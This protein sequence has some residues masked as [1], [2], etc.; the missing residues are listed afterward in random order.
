[1]SSPLLIS[2]ISSYSLGPLETT[3]IHWD[4]LRHNDHLLAIG[5]RYYM[6]ELGIFSISEQNKQVRYKA[7][8]PAGSL[9]L[10]KEM[11]LHS[12]S[13][14]LFGFSQNVGMGWDPAMLTGPQMLILSTLGGLRAE[15]GTPL[16]LGYHTGHWELGLL[17]KEAAVELRSLGSLPFA[18]HCSDPCDGRSQGTS[19]MMDSL[20]YRNT[21][22]E[23]FG[24]LIR[25]L[26][27][28]RGVMGI[29]TCDKG[30]PAMMMALAAARDLPGILV[31]GGVTLPPIDGEDA[32]TVQSMGARYAHGELSIEDA[33]RLGCVACASPGGGCQ[34]LGTAASS[35]VI[36]EALG[37]SLPHSALVPSGE[38]VWLDLARASA[39]A[40]IKLEKLKIRMRDI[41]TPG[42]FHNALAVH[43]AV[44]G[45]TNLLLHVPA[46]AHAVG[47]QRPTVEDWSRVN[48]EV[49]RFVDVLP[50]GPQ[51]FKTVQLYLAGGIPEVMLHLRD[52]GVLDLEV[53]TVTGKTL[54]ENLSDWENSERREYFRNELKRQDGVDPN[55]VILTPKQAKSQGFGST[56]VFPRGN[57]AP[58]G[59]VVK[60]TAI[61][62]SLCPDGIYSHRGPARVFTSED[63]AIAAIKSSGSDA[64]H[65]GDIIVL[66]CRGPIGAGLPETSQI[67]MALK[68]TKALKHVA[69]ITD[70]R[71]SGFSSGPCIGHVGPEALAGGPIGKILDGDII[72]IRIDRNSLVGTIELVG[73]KE[74]AE[75]E[76]SPEL[77]VRLLATRA[78]RPDL[79]PDPALPP[80]T[81]LW[82]VL[83]QSGG[84]IWGGCV[85]DIE[86]VVQQ[87]RA[88]N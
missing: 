30:L 29:A 67:T 71:F 73:S 52:L 8:G 58:D 75:S 17:I 15:D 65:Q 86:K 61:D 5:Y 68:Y 35:Q 23:V 85:T 81:L 66:V 44:G 48:H 82:G 77:G 76:L 31:P 57:L 84:G 83:Q 64:V 78:Q 32:G 63:S 62:A 72:E 59:S 55:E 4:N 26:P 53:L 69:L 22:A 10:T 20:P 47:V 80:E 45:S 9:P 51:N 36:A 74:T 1:M 50:N 88:P 27:T 43:A 40:L 12:P 11:L 42:A 18:A 19:G 3:K 16:A 39:R 24:R 87:L 25:S 14:D 60:A 21:A 2:P 13:G 6:D 56:V 7:V 46:I 49:Q 38:P 79:T 41:L 33:A 54:R 34:F 37:M 70:G 28:R